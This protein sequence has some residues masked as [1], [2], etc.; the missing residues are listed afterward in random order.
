MNMA[1]L[2]P[3]NINWHANVSIA[4]A[5]ILLVALLVQQHPHRESQ[6]DNDQFGAHSDGL[7]VEISTGV[8]W[9]STVGA[10]A[11]GA[12]VLSLRSPFDAPL[13]KAGALTVVFPAILLLLARLKLV[14]FFF[15]DQSAISLFTV[16]CQLLMYT[17][18][19]GPYGDMR[20]V[21]TNLVVGVVFSLL[22]KVFAPGAWPSSPEPVATPF[23]SDYIR[24]QTTHYSQRSSWPEG[25]RYSCL[26]AAHHY[27]QLVWMVVII[28]CMIRACSRLKVRLPSGRLHH[29]VT[30]M[31][32]L[33]VA[34]P[35]LC[36]LLMTH[37]AIQ[38]STG[39]AGDLAYLAVNFILY[40]WRM[41]IYSVIMLNI[42][43]AANEHERE[44]LLQL[45]DAEQAKA[46]AEEVAATRRSF[47]RYVFHEASYNP[48][49]MPPVADTYNCEHVVVAYPNKQSAALCFLCACSYASQ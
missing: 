7:N 19:A 44:I 11:F 39:R 13:I 28:V 18:C 30:G 23:L 1:L 17:A 24:V 27:G 26:Y 22:P 6:V 36:S 10:V 47:L 41:D 43:E 37:P 45:K 29:V 48:K 5:A 31:Q 2:T 4:V 38:Q 20:L 33:H 35:P 42:L 3:E 34:L 49:E 15:I 14:T 40:P 16:H 25:R 12:K 21:V 46:L 8:L 32:L 9:A